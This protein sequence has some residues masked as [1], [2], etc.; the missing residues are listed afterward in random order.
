MKGRP[1]SFS[2]SIEHNRWRHVFPNFF[3]FKKVVRCR[4]LG[5]VRGDQ[6]GLSK[7]GDSIY[8]NKDNFLTII[9]LTTIGDT[10]IDF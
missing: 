5:L 1:V 4:A 8:C 6:L 9:L 7:L 10:L 2:S 3:L